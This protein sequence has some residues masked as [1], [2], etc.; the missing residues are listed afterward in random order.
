MRKPDFIIVGAAKSGTTTLYENLKN[1]PNICLVS[2]RLEF[3]GEYA[4]PA[5]KPIDLDEYLNLYRECGSDVLAGEKSVS[6]LYSVSAAEE[7]Y[8]VNKNMKIIII[9]RDPV[10]RAYS[11]YWHRK[12]TNVENLTF[13]EALRAERQRIDSGQRFELHYREYGNYYQKIKKYLDV[14]GHENVL[15]LKYDDL[16]SDLES[17]LKRCEKF[18]GI[19]QS[20]RVKD[21]KIHNK[22]S[23][24]SDNLVVKF[25][26]ILYKRRAL[27]RGVNLFIPRK[28]ITVITNWMMSKNSTSGY[29]KMEY[30]TQVDLR[31]YYREDLEKIE[32]LL[33]WNLNDWK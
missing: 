19:S 9:L 22:G 32:G 8:A 29:P 6:Y 16:K 1:H 17:T 30:K 26:Y 28:L 7:M 23:V 10:E 33:N 11:D 18:L 20:L 25:L 2:D 4:N 24:G 3:F 5:S 13:E 15:I 21:S 14:F 27:V 31:R 12:R